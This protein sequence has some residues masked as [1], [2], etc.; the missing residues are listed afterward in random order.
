MEFTDYN[1]PNKAL[2][3]GDIQLNSFQTIQFM[4]AWNKKHK[5]TITNVGKTY[6][7]PMRA[8]S[9]KVSSLTKLT[10]NAKVSVP[11]DAANE[12][13]ALQLLEANGLIKLKPGATSLTTRDITENKLN[14][15]ITELDAAQTARSMH[16]VDAAIVNND[17]AAAA[18]LNPKDAI[19]VEKIGKN[20]EPFINVIAAASKKDKDNK[21][22]QKVVQAYQTKQTE[23]LMAKFYKGSTVPAWK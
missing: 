23:K 16:D 11:N 7:G 20:S 1:T 6:L 22:Y 19:N 12:G 4:E 2:D 10:K 8:Y 18:K 15:K 14:L 17:I 5:D 13:R 21:T 9:N 3:D